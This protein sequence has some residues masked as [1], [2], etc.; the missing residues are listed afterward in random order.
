MLKSPILWLVVIVLA[1]ALLT[2]IGPVEKTLGTNARVVYLHGVWVWAALTCFV[3]AGLFGLVGLLTRRQVFH[4][5]SRALGRTGLLLWI[6]YLP[7]SMWAMQ[8]SWNGLYLSEPRWRLA[9]I[10]A[11]TGLLLQ[12]GVTLLEDAAW[13]SAANLGFIILLLIALANTANVMHPPSPILNSDARRIQL[14]FFLLFGLM[15]SAAWQIA[16]W[17]HKFETAS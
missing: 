11:L 4:R 9:V 2:A 14:Y 7:V 6:T 12:V 17:W 15:L 8:T 5:W 3:A 13:A 1:I 16:R 10:F